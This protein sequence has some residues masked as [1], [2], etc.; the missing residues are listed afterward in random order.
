MK[1]LNVS[2]ELIQVANHGVP[3]QTCQNV[4]KEAHAWFALP[5]TS[6]TL[7][8]MISMHLCGLLLALSHNMQLCLLHK[9]AA[10]TIDTVA[11]AGIYQEADFDP[12][13]HTLQGLSAAR[14]QCDSL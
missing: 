13:R 5:V 6:L 9:A 14:C 2:I 10:I 7:S 12:S 8:C 1:R 4:L 3:A 11:N